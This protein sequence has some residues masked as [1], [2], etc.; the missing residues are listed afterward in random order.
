MGAEFGGIG[1]RLR[2]ERAEK[3]AKYWR[4]G[5]WKQE[6]YVSPHDYKKAQREG[7]KE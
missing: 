4:R 7:S 6:E 5:M 1:A 2:Y 3:W